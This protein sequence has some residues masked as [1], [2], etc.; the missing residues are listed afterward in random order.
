[1]NTIQKFEN[2]LDS[3]IKPAEKFSHDY[4]LIPFRA[5]LEKL[6]PLAEKLN[7]TKLK[8]FLQITIFPFFILTTFPIGFK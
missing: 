4:L 6:D 1:M 5:A 8:R 7:G 2:W 3:A